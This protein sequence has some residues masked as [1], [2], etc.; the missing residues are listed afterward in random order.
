MKWQ[1]ASWPVYFERVI[2]KI[3]LEDWFE[4]VGTYDSACKNRPKPSAALQVF[5]F[6]KLFN[7]KVSFSPF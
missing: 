4:M 7:V 3:I 1:D 2:P 6:V 5:L